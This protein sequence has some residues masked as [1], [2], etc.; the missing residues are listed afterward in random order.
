MNANDPPQGK[1]KL[2]GDFEKAVKGPVDRPTQNIGQE[3]PPAPRLEMKG[4]MGDQVRRTVSQEMAIERA[5]R[6]SAEKAR[7]GLARED[8]QQGT[9]KA[10]SDA[11]DRA[12]RLKLA[13]QFNNRARYKGNERE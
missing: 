10:N 11:I 4:P 9:E 12:R 7:A 8:R 1:G 2:R 3:R 6:L 5:K 13:E